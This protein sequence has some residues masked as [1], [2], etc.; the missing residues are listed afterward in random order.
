LNDAQ[1]EHERCA[2]ENGVCEKLEVLL[3]VKKED[4]SLNG[5]EFDAQ[6]VQSQEEATLEQITYVSDNSQHGLH[7]HDPPSQLRNGD[8]LLRGYQDDTQRAEEFVSE[9]LQPFEESLPKVD[10]NLLYDVQPFQCKE[11]PALEPGSHV[12]EFALPRQARGDVLL[13]NGDDGN[14]SS[15]LGSAVCD[16]LNF[17][18]AASTSKQFPDQSGPAKLL[19]I[20]QALIPLALT[21]KKDARKKLAST[22]KKKGKKSFVELDV[23][24][25][26]PSPKKASLDRFLSP[27]ADSPSLNAL[28][29][30]TKQKQF[31]TYGDE[32][33]VGTFGTIKTIKSYKPVR[34]AEKEKALIEAHVDSIFDDTAQERR[35]W[36][37]KK[38][39]KSNSALKALPMR[40]SIEEE[41]MSQ[42]DDAVE[43]EAKHEIKYVGGGIPGNITESNSGDLTPPSYLEPL[44][45]EMVDDDGSF[46]QEIK[47]VLDAENDVNMDSD[48]NATI[49]D[50]PDFEV[51]WKEV[52]EDTARIGDEN[53]QKQTDVPE[54]AQMTE[55]EAIKT[56]LSLAIFQASISS[57]PG[58]SPSKGPEK[59]GKQP[60]LQASSKKS[61]RPKVRVGEK[62]Y[63]SFFTSKLNKAKTSECRKL[64]PPNENETG[65]MV[66]SFS[67]L[68][69]TKAILKDDDLLDRKSR[70]DH[71]ATL[72]KSKKITD[73]PNGNEKRRFPS[74]AISKSRAIASESGSVES[75]SSSKGS[76]KSNSDSIT[77]LDLLRKAGFSTETKQTDA[78]TEYALELK[79]RGK[80]LTTVAGLKQ[81]M[82]DIRKG[83]L[84]SGKPPK[85]GKK[86]GRAAHTGNIVRQKSFKAPE[87]QSI[88]EFQPAELTRRN[89]FSDV[90]F[91]GVQAMSNDSAR[92]HSE[93]NDCL[94]QS[95]DWNDNNQS[96][97]DASFQG[98]KKGASKRE[99][100][101]KK[102]SLGVPNPL[103][104]LFF[105]DFVGKES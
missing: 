103:S 75:K 66:K 10:N 12:C 30:K 28:F 84:S 21:K 4:S 82:Q 71:K 6:H 33:S 104:S 92:S 63:V 43:D 40:D 87:Q 99:K 9:N 98:Q 31:T 77:A 80:K 76:K 14:Y 91:F 38:S 39:L 56:P 22:R 89:S 90:N 64:K 5:C 46:E 17:S 67:N 78:A 83:G 86:A 8:N 59:K 96:P 45:D 32:I 79:K 44:L 53:N 2:G 93:A 18:T 102:P 88:F 3:C 48:L 16:D 47:I 73:K 60:N 20:N 97:T 11:E 57:I 65:I 26:S 25:Q 72:S 29:K 81:E 69:L 35:P 51:A 13:S 19:E 41:E 94:F 7:F 85:P 36:Q 23:S 70:S 62:D 68:D 58:G 42:A 55:E 105:G 34:R 54:S 49:A 1:E 50:Q 61:R 52:L 101:K 37:S 27:S 95:F 15:T 24:P 100:K 74:R